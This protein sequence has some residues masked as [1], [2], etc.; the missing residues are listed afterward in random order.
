MPTDSAYYRI[1]P[2]FLKSLAVA[3]G[4]NITTSAHSIE[5]HRNSCLGMSL[6]LC[7]LCCRLQQH[8]GMSFP[9]YVGY[10]SGNEVLKRYRKIKRY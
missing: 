7:H 10:L 9:I 8:N 1:V 6:P 4:N 2:L 3:E 5:I